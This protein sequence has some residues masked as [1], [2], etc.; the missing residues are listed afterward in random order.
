MNPIVF[1]SYEVLS[2]QFIEKESKS[3]VVR[4][5]SEGGGE[6]GSG[7]SQVSVKRSRDG[8]GDG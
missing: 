1:Q 7:G 4:R 6:L 3:G 5:R 8:G 2:S